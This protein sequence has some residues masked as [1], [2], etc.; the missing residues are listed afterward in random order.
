[1]FQ[2][3]IYVYIPWS[4]LH[5]VVIM[6]A[7][8]FMTDLKRVIWDLNRLRSDKDVGESSLCVESFV[9]APVPNQEHNEI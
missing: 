8:K 1:M 2:A 5:Y 4:F 9:L 7:I 6:E 3:Y